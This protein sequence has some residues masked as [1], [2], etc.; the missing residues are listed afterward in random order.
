MRSDIIT[1]VDYLILDNLDKKTKNYPSMIAK[2]IGC[3][4]PTISTNIQK[5]NDVKIV[6]YEQNRSDRTKKWY[7]LTE[8]GRSFLSILRELYAEVGLEEG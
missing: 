6:D 2:E 5:F 8:K 3:K 4:R 7:F 1:M